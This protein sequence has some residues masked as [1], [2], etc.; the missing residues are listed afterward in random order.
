[1]KRYVDVLHLA[2]ALHKTKHGKVLARNVEALHLA[3][4]T[5]L[6]EAE[7][8]LVEA[9]AVPGQPRSHYSET[10][11]NLALLARERG[12]ADT[13]ASWLEKIATSDPGYR[14]LTPHMGSS[15]LDARSG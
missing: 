14:D 11:Y 7:G 2:Q 10:M 3:A 1:M 12:A 13:A 8:K 15:R 4:S 6:A 5:R 9:L